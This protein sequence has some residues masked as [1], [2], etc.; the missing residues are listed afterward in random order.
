MSEQDQSPDA[1]ENSET[2]PVAENKPEP[3]EPQR[4]TFDEAQ[5]RELQRIVAREVQAAKRRAQQEAEESRARQEAEAKGEY[6]KLLADAERQRDEYR[7]SI[8]HMEAERVVERIAKRSNAEH[9]EVIY[10]L[11]KD[12]IQYGDDG[13]P[14]NVEE[15][16]ADLKRD[17]PRYFVA[18]VAVGADAGKSGGDPATGDMNQVLRRAANRR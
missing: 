3:Q 15:L 8:R 16:V 13:K 14:T 12:D 5:Q 17:Y 7:D 1:Q 6:Q 18:P 4:V 11:I 10:R 2:V 9:P